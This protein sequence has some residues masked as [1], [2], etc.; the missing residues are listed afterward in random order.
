VKLVG[1]T[2]E[3]FNPKT[4]QGVKSRDA[5]KGSIASKLK[6]CGDGTQQC[7][8]TDVKIISI[9]RRRG[10]VT[11]KFEVLASPQAKAADVTSAS[12]DLESFL[13]N[14][15]PTSGFV[16]VLIQKAKT[17]GAT[18]LGSKNVSD[19]TATVTQ[20]PK[21]VKPPTPTPTPTP[22]IA[23][24]ST[25]ATVSLASLAFVALALQ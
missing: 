25:T 19:I 14:T 21:V 9:S 6:I 2:L 15:N 22:T 8:K 16:A 4:V 3:T 12:T 24:A 10:E 20:A 1:L 5:L 17:E 18:V 11:V 7:G 13:K 23:A